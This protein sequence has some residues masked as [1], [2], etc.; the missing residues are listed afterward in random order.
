MGD[1]S[2]LQ[3]EVGA[4]GAFKLHDEGNSESQSEVHR[5]PDAER[6]A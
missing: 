6:Q 1:Q 3:R 2:G 5:E 4:G